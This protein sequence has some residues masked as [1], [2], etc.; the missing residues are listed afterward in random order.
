[1]GKTLIEMFSF[2]IF[3]K[4]LYFVKKQREL[5]QGPINIFE[6]PPQL[7]LSANFSNSIYKY[8]FDETL[9]GPDRTWRTTLPATKIHNAP[10][11]DVCTFPLRTRRFR[12]LWMDQPRLVRSI[13]VMIVVLEKWCEISRSCGRPKHCKT[14]VITCAKIHDCYTHTHQR[15]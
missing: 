8:P 6:T 9:V 2:F 11:A 12:M 13:M 1:M 10:K 14:S 15:W 3:K 4:I 5:I 7:Q